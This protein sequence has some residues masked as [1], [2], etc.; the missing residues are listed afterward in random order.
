MD[1][2]MDEVQ[3]ADRQKSEL[4]RQIALFA[5]VRGI[6]GRLP[7]LIL[8]SSD[9]LWISAVE[10]WR[11]LEGQRG[12]AV[13]APVLIEVRQ[14]TEPWL[15]V[16]VGVGVGDSCSKHWAENRFLGDTLDFRPASRVACR[17]KALSEG[18]SILKVARDT[19]YCHDLT[20]RLTHNKSTPPENTHTHTEGTEVNKSFVK[21]KKGNFS[22]LSLSF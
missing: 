22:T 4:M 14:Q 19:V 11:G 9:L 20:L 21:L 15:S 1:G 2:K 10:K 13:N 6:T 5:A 17:Q 16:L 12:D 18:P 8:P 3:A 7:I